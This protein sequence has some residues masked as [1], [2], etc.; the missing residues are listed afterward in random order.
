MMYYLSRSARNLAIL[1]ALF[2]FFCLSGCS[3][4]SSDGDGLHDVVLTDVT[5]AAGIGAF[6]HDNGGSGESWA[7]EIV[8]GGGGFIDYN[9][10]GWQDMLL[11]AGG[12]FREKNDR[13]V[14]TL[15]LYRNN[16]D[17]TFTLVSEEAGLWDIVTYGYGIA[18]GDYDID[19][20]QDFFLTSLYRNMLFR[21]DGGYFT[22]VGLEAGFTER[23][24]WSMSTMFIDVDNDRY[25]DVF[26]ANYAEWTPEIDIYCPFE[27]EK[28]FCTPELF[29][30]QQNRFYH[31]NG[32]GT[33]SDWSDETGVSDAIEPIR[34]KV[35]GVAELDFNNDG[36]PDM[37]GT[38]DTERDLLYVNNGDGTFS[39]RG[40][41]AGIAFDKHGKARAGMGVV[42]GVVDSTGQTTIFVGHFTEETIGVFQHKGQGVFLER[43]AVSKIGHA[44]LLTLTFGIILVDIDLDGDLDLICANGHVQEHIG[45]ML[46][47]IQFK[48]PPQLYLNRGDGIFD[49]YEQEGGVFADSMVARCASYADYDRDGDLDILIVENNGPAHLW[50]NDSN[51]GN[52][53]RVRLKGRASNP[54]A[55]HTRILAYVDGFGREQRIHSG[56]S[57]LSQ[58]ENT[59]TFGFGPASVVDSLVIC[60]PSGTIDRFTGLDMNQEILVIEGTRMYETQPLKERNWSAVGRP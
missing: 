46:E 12:P 48:I 17:G 30:G 32:D 27:G 1:F 11:V 20:D 39:E 21:N 49:E 41:F 19:G 53:L 43:A 34:N 29:D 51:G 59:A 23:D 4:S 47:G 26:Y 8:G 50:R 22:E 9:G 24:E 56:S 35:L 37:Y 28:V 57:F 18:A 52:F 45:K 14:H 10:D 7:P 13:E 15:W 2:G 25:V 36:W 42:N 60:W 40:I 16:Q 44:S 5:D 31:N 33:F 58:Q 3:V 6:R 38:N 54:D 55:Y